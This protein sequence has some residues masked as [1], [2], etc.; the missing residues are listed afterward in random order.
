MLLRSSGGGATA[1]HYGTF[2]FSVIRPVTDSGPRV[3]IRDRHD[4]AAAFVLGAFS[5]RGFRAAIV[6][7][8]HRAGSAA[9]PVPLDPED[10]GVV[11]RQRASA[12]RVDSHALCVRGATRSPFG[13]E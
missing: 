5:R 1:A 4:E 11:P 6:G 7:S 2:G 12:P 3:N 8:L 9:D 13:L 10:A